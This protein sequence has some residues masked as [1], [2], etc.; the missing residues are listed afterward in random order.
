M[1]PLGTVLPTVK[2]LKATDDFHSRQIHRKAKIEGLMSGT[3]KV[4]QG[5]VRFYIN[6][7]T[8]HE[9]GNDGRI[10]EFVT[11][12]DGDYFNKFIPCPIN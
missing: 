7:T 8:Y 1:K 5:E 9:V 10:R 12:S 4:V 3:R 6:E 11:K 2:S